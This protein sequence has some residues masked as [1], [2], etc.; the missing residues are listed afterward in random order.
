MPIY[1]FKCRN[2]ECIDYDKI[3]EIISHK[4]YD[5]EIISCEHCGKP[6]IKLLSVFGFDLKGTGFHKN[7]YPS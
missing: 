6:M 5:G 2:K 3:K 4:F 1:E 7:D